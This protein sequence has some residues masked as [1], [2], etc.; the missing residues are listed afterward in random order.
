MCCANTFKR[1]ITQQAGAGAAE[2]LSTANIDPL[3]GGE[4]RISSPVSIT[5]AAPCRNAVV[6]GQVCDASELHHKANPTSATASKP[7]F[8]DGVTGILTLAKE[9]LISHDGFI[10]MKC[11]P[12][13][14]VDLVIGD[15]DHQASGLDRPGAEC[16]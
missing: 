3:R 13:L 10:R 7:A 9:L 14:Q 1:G 15:P 8:F 11:P 2:R 16:P 5:P 12:V 4:S 6:T